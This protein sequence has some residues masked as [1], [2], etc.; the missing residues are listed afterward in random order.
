MRNVLYILFFFIIIGLISVIY[1]L[2]TTFYYKKYPQKFLEKLT[3]INNQSGIQKIDENLRLDSTGYNLK[4]SCLIL[5]YTTPELDSNSIEFFETGLNL[6]YTLYQ[7]EYKKISTL[8][9]YGLKLKY[10]IFDKNGKIG[11]TDILEKYNDY[12]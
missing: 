10:Q 8:N 1:D 4:D 11:K 3:R 12:K 6:T 2:S 9:E 7:V 5:Y